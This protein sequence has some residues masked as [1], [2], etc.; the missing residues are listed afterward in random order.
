M[1]NQY[2]Y[3]SSRY[4]PAVLIFI[5]TMLNLAIHK[6]DFTYHKL[7]LHLTIQIIVMLILCY[8]CIKNK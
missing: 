4:L 7:L 2:E 1:N 6:S 8:E 3:Y 5:N